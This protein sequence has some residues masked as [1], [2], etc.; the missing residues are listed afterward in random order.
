[1]KEGDYVVTTQDSGSKDWDYSNPAYENRRWGVRGVII[2][3]SSRHGQCFL[4]AHRDPE[5]LFRG[6]GDDAWYE[7]KELRLES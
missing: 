3:G 6:T 4:I 1:M 2:R 5:G 7:E